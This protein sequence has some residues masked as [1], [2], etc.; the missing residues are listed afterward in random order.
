[1]SSGSAREF[2]RAEYFDTLDL[3]NA[4]RAHMIR[5]RTHKLVRYAGTGLGELYNLAEDPGEFDN[6][7]D[8]DIRTR[9]LVSEQLLDAL[10]IAAD[11][12]APR[13][14]RF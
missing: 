7:W 9:G 11:V 10:T 1:M 14:G 12:G 8:K 6:L 13:I 4:T 2:V 5:T 3:P